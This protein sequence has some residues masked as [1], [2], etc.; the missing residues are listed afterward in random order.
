[1]RDL[2]EEKRL[3]QEREAFEEELERQLLMP[4]PDFAAGKSY[5]PYKGANKKLINSLLIS[6]VFTIIIGVGGWTYSKNHFD[7]LSNENVDK[8]HN[9]IQFSVTDYYQDNNRYPV[10]VHGNIDFVTLEKRGYL[11]LDIEVYKS[12]FKYDSSYNVIRLD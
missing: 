10:D 2:D 5:M 4:A 9:A 1:M 7:S 6:L 11:T 8:I 12:K 3:E